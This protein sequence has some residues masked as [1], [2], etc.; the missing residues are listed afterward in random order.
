VADEFR[1]VPLAAEVDAFQTEIRGDQ[2]FIAGRDSHYSTI[3][4]DA[5]EHTPSDRCLAAKACDQGFFRSWQINLGD[6][7]VPSAYF[8][9]PED[10][11]V[12]PVPALSS[13]QKSVQAPARPAFSL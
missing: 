8:P 7:D 4:T 13:P 3:V 1:R 11:T 5:F 9:L 6:L 10:D 2:R 12:S